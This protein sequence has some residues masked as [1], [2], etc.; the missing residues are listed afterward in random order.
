MFRGFFYFMLD[1]LLDEEDYVAA[2]LELKDFAD[3]NGIDLDGSSKQIV[4]V[5]TTLMLSIELED[6]TFVMLAKLIYNVG[7]RDNHFKSSIIH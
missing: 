7:Y 5:A 2:I 1:L 6:D 4:E 3:K